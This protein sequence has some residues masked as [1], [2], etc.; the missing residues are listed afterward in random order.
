MSVDRDEISPE[1][2]RAL[3]PLG[4]FKSPNR[5]M[6]IGTAVLAGGLVPWIVLL[7]LTLPPRYDAGHWRVL[8]VGYDVGEVLVLAFAAW[9]AWFRRQILIP[10]SLVTAVLL[11]CDAWFDIV[12]SWGHRDEWVT[13][14]T[15]LGAEIP[16]GL[17]F[18]WLCRLLIRRSIQAF[19][20]ALG[21]DVAT[22]Q[23]LGQTFLFLSV[24]QRRSSPV[25]D[26]SDGAKDL[27][28]ATE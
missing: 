11:F 13:L 6:A 5:A 20:E 23:L 15:G 3:G 22:A 8:W 18:L 1:D 16:L 17:F 19:H 28:G 12:I 26:S 9:A 7:G 21:D 10:I 2:R 27:S 14:A 25:S 24:P 4:R